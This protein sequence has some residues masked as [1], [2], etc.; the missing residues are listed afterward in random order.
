MGCAKAL[1]RL[2]E[3][4]KNVNAQREVPLSGRSNTVAGSKTVLPAGAGLQ[5]VRATSSGN[6]AA[7]GPG[8]C[9]RGTDFDNDDLVFRVQ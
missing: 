7:D 8:P 4:Q 5:A 2:W 9:A 3:T 1:P 6:G